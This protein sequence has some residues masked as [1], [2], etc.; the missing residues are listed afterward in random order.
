MRSA[1]SRN[2]LSS[3]L[4]RLSALSWLILTLIVTYLTSDLSST[5]LTASQKRMAGVRS[6]LF[7][8]VGS[9]LTFLTRFSLHTEEALLLLLGCLVLG[10]VHSSPNAYIHIQAFLGKYTSP[11]VPSP[12]IAVAPNPNKLKT[13]NE[14]S[15]PAYRFTELLHVVFT[16]SRLTPL[17]IMRCI[18]ST[19]NEKREKSAREYFRPTQNERGR[20]RR[21]YLPSKMKQSLELLD[22]QCSPYSNIH[23]HT[24]VYSC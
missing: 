16:P 23:S 8:P 6:A 18:L 13:E 12:S 22:W 4:T 7:S 24:L 3:R 21:S 9:L 14:N 10:I 20:R 19:R 17:F 15:H 11:T 2:F 1:I 5:S